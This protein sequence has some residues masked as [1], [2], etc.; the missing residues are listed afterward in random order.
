MSK[1]ILICTVI[2][3]LFASRSVAQGTP[4][5]N[6]WVTT[7]FEQY[8][9]K[10][11]K[12]SAA[13]YS[14]AFAT[15]G[16]RAVADDRYI[17]ACAWALAGKR[18]SAFFHLTYLA[19][20][21]NYTDHNQLTTDN[22]LKVLR[23]D[24]RWHPLCDRVQQNMVKAEATLNKNLVAILDTVSQQDQRYRQQLADIENQHGKN[25][26]EVKE[27]WKII[28]K[29]D[30][31]NLKKVTAILEQYGWP[32]ADLVGEEGAATVFL[33]IQHADLKTQDKY[34]PSMREAVKKGIASPASL[35]MLE[36]RVAL[37]HGKKQIY[38]SQVT[39][40]ANGD[41]LAPLA[42]PDNVDKRR[43]EVGL[44]P[45]ADYLL[46]FS[47]IWDVAAYKKQLPELEKRQKK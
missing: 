3:F 33:V 24:K 18:D 8:N 15:I 46:N 25:S 43:A 9:A 31:V 45:L 17:A 29:Y 32:G 5:Y 35:A 39:S 13:S 2:T 37:R 12:E 40:D 30:S 21:A 34:L 36:D 27:L 4:E 28:N 10:Q 19:E 42:D 26:K 1:F 20:K 7:G 23:G 38:G 41:Y 22:D 44:G 6:K 16:G 47:I 14:K 11:Y